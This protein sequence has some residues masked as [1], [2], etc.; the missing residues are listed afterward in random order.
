VWEWIRA[1]TQPLEQQ[2]EQLR[3]FPLSISSLKHQRPSG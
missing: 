2:W 1:L 3:H